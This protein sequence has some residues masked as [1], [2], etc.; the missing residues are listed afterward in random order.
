MITVEQWLKSRCEALAKDGKIKPLAELIAESDD[1]GA[2][3][4]AVY[5][6]CMS[7]R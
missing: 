2:P 1:K 5:R 7:F 4:P 6:P 3:L